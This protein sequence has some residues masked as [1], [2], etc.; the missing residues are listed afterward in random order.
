MESPQS[1]RLLVDLTKN[2]VHAPDG[3]VFNFAI[4]ASDRHMLL[5]GID[6]IDFTLQYANDI[7]GFVA[8]DRK[9]R[10]WAY[11]PADATPR[12]IRAL[13]SSSL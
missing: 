12:E 9:V 6:Y 8:D 5:N 13:T 2:E 4:D 11:L 1:Q 10:P 7:D 3:Q